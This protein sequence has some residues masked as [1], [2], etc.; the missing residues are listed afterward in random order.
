MFGLPA[1]TAKLFGGGNGSPS[2]GLGADG[3]V[4]GSVTQNGGSAGTGPTIAALD[5]SKHVVDPGP[6]PMQLLS[7]QQYLNTIK[8][9]A[10]DVPGLDQAFD[11]DTQASAF[12]LV[13]PDVSQV[14]LEHYQKAADT[15]AAVM[16]TNQ[17]TL[18]KVAPCAMGAAPADCAKNLVQKFGALAYRAPVTDAADIDR[19][20]QL[21]N[22][23]ATTSYAHGVEM[24]LRGMLQSPR[25]LYR[26]EV[27][28]AEKVSDVAVKLSGYEVAARLSY[29]LWDSPP[30]DELNQAVGSGALATKEGVTAQLAWMLED[31]RGAKLVN[32]FL[33]SWTHIGAVGGLVKNPDLYPEFQSSS[34]K[35]SLQGQAAAFFDDVLTKQGGL[36]QRRSGRLLR[37]HGRRHVS[38]AAKDRRHG[39][40]YLDLAGALGGTR[41]T[42]RELTDLSRPLRA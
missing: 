33:E 32:R 28:T 8:E 5:C 4:G 11:D 14:Q 23:G 35:A 2:N 29:T 25:F 20:V 39:G 1:C 19:H 12:G 16:V 36:L 42:E 17:T 37:R 41:Q 10:G 38:V 3:G 18:N 31:A 7:R 22:V 30:N 15:V 27:G 40:R 13:Q 21:F 24:L 26:V 34:F 6:S 9:L